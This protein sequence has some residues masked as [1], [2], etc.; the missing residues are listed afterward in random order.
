MTRIIR[1]IVIVIMAAM[2]A[3]GVS[4]LFAAESSTV[5]Q[6]VLPRAFFA[7]EVRDI[8][9][10]TIVY[11]EPF[12]C[13]MDFAG[14]LWL[15]AA[16]DYRTE[17]FETD[18]G[19]IPT[20]VTMVPS[21]KGLRAIV[22]EIDHGMTFASREPGGKEFDAT[23]EPEGTWILIEKVVA[24]ENGKKGEAGD[25]VPVEQRG[26]RIWAVPAGDVYM[27]LRFIKA[28]LEGTGWF[29]GNVPVRRTQFTDSYGISPRV[30]IHERH[31]FVDIDMTGVTTGKIVRTWSSPPT[32]TM[33]V[34]MEEAARKAADP[35]AAQWVNHLV[36]RSWIVPA[37]TAGEASVSSNPPP[38]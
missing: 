27:S 4:P 13:R 34:H 22:A 18:W 14:R 11:V 1:Q 5:Q 31:T 29:D 24:V 12:R 17:P 7:P 20:K 10:K 26:V 35:T 2:L 37:S 28:G 32:Q 36:V 19:Y 16:T 23:T 38:R 21:P 3:V 25:L 30:M 9:K 33:A 15:R 6:K 8:A